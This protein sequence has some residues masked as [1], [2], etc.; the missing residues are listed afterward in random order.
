MMSDDGGGKSGEI[1]PFPKTAEERRAIRKA[2]LD[3]E[4]QRLGNRFIDE[5][6]GD[7]ALFHTANDTA[8]ADLIVNGHRETWPVRSKQFRFSYLRYLKRQKDR[9]A[10]VDPVLAMAINMRKTA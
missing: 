3:Q 9:L 10:G 2:K 5:A 4:R 1:V 6:G 7:T 8:Y